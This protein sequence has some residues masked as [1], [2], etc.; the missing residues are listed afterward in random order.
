MAATAIHCVRPRTKRAET[1]FV[2]TAVVATLA[3]T[4]DAL[5]GSEI[6]FRNQDIR[7]NFNYFGGPEI[8]EEMWSWMQS[9]GHEVHAPLLAALKDPERFAAAHILLTSLTDVPI[10]GTPEGYNGLKV[11]TPSQGGIVFDPEQ[12][13]D[14]AEK[15]ESALRGKHF[16][17][18]RNPWPLQR[19]RMSN[20]RVVW[21][22]TASAPTFDESGLAY[23]A[24]NADVS[25][26][27]A[28]FEFRNADRFVAAHVFLATA[29]GV[30]LSKASDGTLTGLRVEFENGDPKK[31][32]YD[33]AQAE[34]LRQ[35]WDRWL[36]MDEDH[37]RA[38]RLAMSVENMGFADAVRLRGP[39]EAKAEP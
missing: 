36:A 13:T 12:R 35:L 19:F 3:L 4:E 30:P 10:P 23:A 25:P 24:R 18:A 7:W 20:A 33:F 17:T 5:A 37:R 22:S 16:G 21:P 32:V 38:V 11:E 8:S 27:R 29:E 39:D 1:A 9:A 14:L 34:G 6:P 26:E 15:W 31:P 2:L 28:I